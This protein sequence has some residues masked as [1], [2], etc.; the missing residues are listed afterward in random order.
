LLDQAEVGGP[1]V[2][3]PISPTDLHELE[4]AERELRRTR[5]SAAKVIAKLIRAAQRRSTFL[6]T[7]E[8]AQFLGVSDQTIR[9]WADAGI[10]PSRRAHP[11]ARR[12]I[13]AKALDGIARL[14]AARRQHVPIRMTDDETAA[15]LAETEE[16]E[17]Q[18]EV[19]GNR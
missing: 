9:N 8:A 5:P 19:A 1:R 12:Q 4:A 16:S 17:D 2:L 18:L 13:P 15:A 6:S 14:R 11:L 3:T 10:L 7:T